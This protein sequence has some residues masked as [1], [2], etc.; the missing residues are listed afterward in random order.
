MPPELRRWCHTSAHET[1]GSSWYVARSGRRPATVNGGEVRATQ[2][3]INHGDWAYDAAGV[4]A[5]LRRV[6]GDLDAGLPVGQMISGATF[7]RAGGPGFNIAAVDWYL[8]QLLRDPVRDF[9]EA[10]G[11]T[12]PWRDLAV[13]AL[14]TRNRAGD[15]TERYAEPPGQASQSAADQAKQYSE[16]C[17]NGWRD[18]GELAGM[19]LQRSGLDSEIAASF[20]RCSSR[21]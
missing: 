14:V 12:D 6:E 2:F 8:G 1:I 4:E 19:R 7:R 3:L 5:L 21:Q 20:A 11:F 16:E 15:L 18:F 9:E 13:A 10:D 17:Q